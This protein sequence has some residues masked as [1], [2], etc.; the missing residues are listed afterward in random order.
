MELQ[1]KN[2][3]ENSLKLSTDLENRRKSRTILEQGFNLSFQELKESIITLQN[4]LD[5]A[6]KEV[7]EIE[8]QVCS[9]FEIV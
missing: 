6:W 7:D 8:A 2:Y 5:I 4:D 1:K 9:L 3:E